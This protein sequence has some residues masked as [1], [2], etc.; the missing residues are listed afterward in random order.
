MSWLFNFPTL[1]LFA[2]GRLLFTKA[3]APTGS[4]GTE[5]PFFLAAETPAHLLNY[6]FGLQIFVYVVLVDDNVL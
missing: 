3:D 6:G 4:E 2:A 5:N 1:Q